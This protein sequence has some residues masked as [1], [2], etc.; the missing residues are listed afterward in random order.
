MKHD[1][2]IKSS[3]AL[4]SSQFYCNRISTW[5]QI[6]RIFIYTCTCGENSTTKRHSRRTHI[7]ITAFPLQSIS[8]SL[9]S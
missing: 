8:Y 4:L 5:Q 1:S 7:R 6:N 2:N 3:E 9:R